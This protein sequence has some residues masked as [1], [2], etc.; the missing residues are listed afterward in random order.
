MFSVAIGKVFPI[1]IDKLVSFTYT[2]KFPGW[3]DQFQP[4][5]F[6][7][8]NLNFYFTLKLYVEYHYR[9]S[10]IDL[11]REKLEDEQQGQNI[12]TFTDIKF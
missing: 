3:V 5:L 4:W 1:V 11:A 9:Q 7:T 12:F 10:S 2:L 6:T 8:K